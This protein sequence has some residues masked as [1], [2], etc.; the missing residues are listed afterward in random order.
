MTTITRDAWSGSEWIWQPGAA[1]LSPPPPPPW[2]SA[3]E[4][5]F[6]HLLFQA[7]SWEVQDAPYLGVHLAQLL[8]RVGEGVSTG[9]LLGLGREGS[10]EVHESVLLYLRVC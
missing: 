10:G 1:T 9:V 3:G 4:W 8:A 7:V 5:L 2:R 6:L